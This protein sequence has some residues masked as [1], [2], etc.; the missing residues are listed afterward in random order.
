VTLRLRLIATGMVVALVGLLAAC[1]GPFNALATADSVCFRGLPVAK[2]AVHSQGTLV[3]VRRVQTKT[4]ESRIEHKL[5]ETNLT[6]PPT[7]LSG[8]TQLCAFAFRGQYAPGAVALATNTQ[9]GKYAVVLV[10]SKHV[11]LVGA[12]VLPALPQRFRHPH[13]KP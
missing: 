6:L 4:L 1:G 7:A 5:H 3:G 12:V 13:V 10:G 11:V 9:S 2:A 8:E